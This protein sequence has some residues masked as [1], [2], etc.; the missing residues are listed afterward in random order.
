MGRAQA[1]IP[2]SVR[3]K[4][5]DCDGLLL[6]VSKMISNEGI[7]MG[8]FRVGVNQDNKFN[9]ATVDM[10]LEVKDVEQLTRVL[11]RMETLPNV[12]EAQ[13]LKPG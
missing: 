9:M 13:R 10:V 5:F 4:A 6:D 7:N 2:V 3:V 1:H 11:T 8:H 12:I